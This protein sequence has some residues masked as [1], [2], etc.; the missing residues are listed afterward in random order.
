MP[1]GPTLMDPMPMAPQETKGQRLARGA[2]A[3]ALVVLGLYTLQKF[4]P[5]LVWAAIFAVALWPLY[6]RIRTGPSGQR[7]TT[8]IP[9]AFTLGVA[10]VFIVPVVLIGVQ[11]AKEAH[12]ALDWLQQI[13]DNGIP[14][15]DFLHR[16]PYGEPAVTAW[17]HDNLSGPGD[18]RALFGRLTQGRGDMGRD[19][20]QQVV[21]R[22]TLFTFTLVTL[23]FLFREGR[24]VIGQL[25]RA[26]TRAFGP[27]GERVGRQMIASIHGTV[28]GLVLVGMG[29]GLILGIVYAFAGVTHPTMF[30]ALTGIAA[31]IPFAAPI[32]FG[33]AALLLAAQ[34]SVVTA[35]VVFA[36]GI[37]VTFAADH[38][39]R[40]V[41]I[42]GA[43][44]LPFLW[45]LLGI[46]GGVEEWGLL[47]LFV[48]PAIMSALILLWRDYAGDSA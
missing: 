28:S 42:G 32:V 23:F 27:N 4:L 6:R 9:L 7:H 46:L 33:I 45:V 37:A 12:S 5:A 30:G 44:R 8:L 26:S 35:I 21:R 1:N 19:A 36:I 13:E 22:L 10:L 25:R 29:E 2:L 24:T 17:W 47:G 16:L 18:A 39:V 3:L 41:L 31:I 11:L 38:F 34:G 48:G 20:G 14:E 43:T 15:P 40:P